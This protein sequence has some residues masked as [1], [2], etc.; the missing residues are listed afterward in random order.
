[1]NE[2]SPILKADSVVYRYPGQQMPALCGVDLDL[3]RGQAVGLLGPNGSGKSTLI[4]LLIG[5]KKTQQGRIYSHTEPRPVIALVPQDYAFYP[6]MTCYENLHFFAGMLDISKPE[7]ARRV[8]SAIVS[9][10]LE[11]FVGKRANQCSGGI[12]R[13]LN[14][15]IALM[16]KPDVLLLDEP[17]VGVDPASRAFLLGQV[18]QLV[19]EGCAVLYATHYMEEVSAICSNVLL[20]DH[21]SVLASG[22]LSSLLLHADGNKPFNDLESLFMYYTSKASTAEAHKIL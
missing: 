7:R 4:D 8:A 11:E 20:L 10:M 21:G 19:S 13:K 1:M 15:S 2:P 12:R 3:F 9:C 16:Q 6:D 22:E 14:L 5:L 18:K 17:T